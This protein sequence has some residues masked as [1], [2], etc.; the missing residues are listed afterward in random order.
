M[1]RLL[2]YLPSYEKASKVF[3]EILQAEQ[4]EFN[5]LDLN[6]E[7]LEKQLNID[8][9]TWGLIIYEKELG[10]RTNL[11]KPLEER[12]SI[13]KSKWR[14]TGK[15]DIA[16]IKA[17]V[18]AYTKSKVD[19]FFNGRIKIEFTNKGT[20]TLNMG[21]MFNAIEE[22]K[23]AHLDYDIAMNYKQKSSEIYIGI[24]TLSGEEV[25]VYPY[26]PKVI[27]SKGDIYIAT[28]SN[29]GLENVT[30]Y[31]PYS[32]KEIESKGK[33]Y[34]ATAGSTGLEK[35]TVYPKEGVI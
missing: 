3:Q 21:D 8:T 20:I 26:S 27:S 14:G 31:P 4:I 5:T 19:I 23:P 17:I 28:G 35:T 7:D 11:N 1:S 22:V 15:V 32:I 2:E 16:L 33:V 29:T 9:A 25:T 30:V 34:I 13:V 18:E 10:A 24:A 12:R 6:I